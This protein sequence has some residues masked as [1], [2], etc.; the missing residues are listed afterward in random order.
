[1]SAERTRS[2]SARR[3][4]PRALAASTRRCS[5]SPRSS[6]SGIF[7]T[8]G[9]VAKLLPAA[10][11]V[12]RGVARG[13]RARARGRARER[14]ARRDVPARRRQLRLPARRVPPDGGLPRRV[15]L[16][17]RDL[18]GHRRDPRARLH[19]SLGSFVT[20]GPTSKIVVAIAVIW[21]ATRRQ[22]LRDEGRRARSTRDRLPEGRRR[23][24]SFVFVG[25]IIGHGARRSHAA[26]QHGHAATA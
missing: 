13:R 20:L 10:G 1:M 23:S 21:I 12:L 8:P 19:D 7:L 24:S 15:A 18:R 22:R 25:P 9:G 26:L 14:R 17:L 11:L 6:A 2:P 3:V 4:A 16:V 5:S